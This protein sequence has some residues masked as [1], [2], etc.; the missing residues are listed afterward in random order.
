MGL[1]DRGKMKWQAALITPEHAAMLRALRGEQELCEKPIVDEFMRNEFDERVAY[2]MEFNMPIE[3]AVWQAGFISHVV[4]R[5]HY[6]EPIKQQLRI[7]REDGAV[8]RLMMAD[9]VGVEVLD[10]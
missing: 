6:V 8:E 2:A 10:D 4:G 9:V 5:V 7:E 3:F 1:K